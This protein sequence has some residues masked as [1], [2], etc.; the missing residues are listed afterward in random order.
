MELS[1]AIELAKQKLGNKYFENYELVLQ[2]SEEEGLLKVI[3]EN[4]KITIIY[5]QL[6]SLFRGLTVVKE[7][8]KEDKF[9]V[10][11]KK[12]FTTNGYM[13]DCSR[14]GVIRVSVLKE[15]I[16]S[17]ALMGMNRLLLYTEDTYQL[18]K[19]PY[20]GYLRGGYSKDDIKELVAWGEAFGVELIPCIQTLGHL[21]RPLR[22][23]PMQNLNDGQ[24]T[25]MVGEP[26]VYEFIEEMIKF[27]KECFHCTDIHVG[28]DESFELG[29]GKYLHKNGFRN[30]VELFT[31][32][33]TK[34]IEICQKYGFSPMIWS[35]MYF[36]LNNPDY[37]YYRTTPLPES[38]IKMV[39]PEVKLVYWDYYHDDEKIY[40]DMISFHKQ[41]KN[42][43]HFAGG[44][45]R[46][47]GFAPSIQGSFKHTVPAMN[48]C[49]KNGI[50][51]VMVTC[52]G[53]NGNECSIHSI[54]PVVAMYSV[55]DYEGTCDLTKVDSLLQ[56]VEEETLERMMLLDLPDMPA[57]KALIPQYNPSKF[58]LYQDP[59]NG[60]FDGQVKDDFA[61][62]YSEFSV[63]LDKASKESKNYS[64]L[65]RN[66]S[67]L[68]SVLSIKVDLGV[69]L[70]KAYKA[71]DKATLKTIA[72]KDIPLLIK[73]VDLLTESSRAQWM[74][75]NRSFGFDVI[76][77]RMGYLKN[78]LET[79]R[80][81]VNQYIGK[82]ID[83]IEELETEILPFNGHDYE[84]CWNW[85]LQT[86]TVHCL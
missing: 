37:E 14:N 41:T 50:K 31:E 44:A 33:M 47:K 69:R 22:W 17:M 85:W 81:L 51:N 1:K 26:K 54:I 71:G 11:F 30:R 12:H 34:V 73:L 75:E 63:K 35:D 60:I 74:S 36:R 25:L 32:H 24:A 62:N 40:D 80:L 83:K 64:K 48:S 42:E 58:F 57:K 84:V 3:K 39:P 19:Y 38:T 21:E 59:L 78:R 55:A 46:W 5:N 56:A 7:H 52:W 68:C 4:G 20:F 70:R 45:W 76:D 2:H 18:D 49:V 67:I 9:E 16:I 53:D 8:A 29:I 77:G 66:L 72:N 43:I 6:A 65:Y 15:K 82:V 10:T 28:M 27:C 61:K 86:V 13:Q 79:A 23:E